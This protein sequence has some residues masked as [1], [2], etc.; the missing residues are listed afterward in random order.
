MEWRNETDRELLS[1][2]RKVPAGVIGIGAP[3]DT[4]WARVEQLKRELQRRG[5]L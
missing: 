4:Y 2:W 1:R 3:G 5:L